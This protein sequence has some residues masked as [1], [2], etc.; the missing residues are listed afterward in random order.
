MIDLNDVRPLGFGGD[1]YDLDAIV[2]GLRTATASWVPRHFPCGRRNGDE[3]RLANILGAAPRKTGSCVITLTGAHAG[4]WIDFETNEGGGPLSALE[5]ATGL[6]GRALIEYA[7]E[8]AGSVAVRSTPVPSSSDRSKDARHEIDIVLARCLPVRGTPVEAYLAGRGLAVPDLS[9][10]LFHPDLTYWETRTG[11]PALV[12]VV[13]NAGGEAVAIH[14]TYLAPN[15]SG[16]ADVLKPR[17]MLGPVSGGAVQ[18][19]PISG[20]GVLGLAEGIETALSVMQACPELPVWA[21]LSAGNLERVILPSDA[22]SIVLLADHDESG[23][24]LEAARKAAERLTAEGRQV[25]LAAPPRAGDD[26]NDLLHRDGL[27]AV[28]TV[29]HTAAAWAPAQSGVTDTVR[30][31]SRAEREQTVDDLPL[32][33]TE[34]ALALEFSARYAEDLRFCAAWG[35]WLMWE[36]RYWKPDETLRAFDLSR[37]TCRAASNRALARIENV[38]AA[39]RMAAALA[40]AKTV[41]AVERLAKADRRHAATVEQW[42]SDEWLLNTPDGIVDLATGRLTPH[43]RDAY[44]TKIAAVGPRGRCPQWRAFLDR[45]SDGD[46]DLQAFL[47]RVAGSALTG[48]IRDHALFFLYGTGRNG[49][50]VFLNTLTRILGDYAVVASIETFT[51][52]NTDRHTTDLAMLRGARLVSAQETEEG[53]RWAESRIKALTGGDPITARF[54]RQDNFTFEPQFKL[55]IA[56]N[57]KPGLRNVDEAIR[58][59]FNLIPFTVTIPESERDPELPAKLQAEWPG[60]LAWAIEGCL[61]W[62]RVGLAPPKAVLDAT[63]A[64][65]EVE[66]ALGRF[67]EERCDVGPIDRLTGEDN[68]ATSTDL[69]ASWQEWCKSTGEY[70]GTQK[71]F[72]QNMQARGFEPWKHPTTRRTGFRGVRLV[73]RATPGTYR[74]PDEG[75]HDR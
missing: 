32:D 26:F 29:V 65:M 8:L 60:I 22:T 30:D 13:R 7:A 74:T 71:R 10:L 18:L 35:R 38:K 72:S 2:A 24:G 64:Y 66:D 15:G 20:D 1:R 5:Y 12:A 17:M 51:A 21:V 19:A 67:L 25:W 43:R 61:E 73:V 75:D 70:A 27:D 47:Q 3:W 55:I 44:M 11:Y 16:K 58:A 6:S 41:A 54:M 69:F 68:V 40:S 56:G 50:G 14:R 63:T 28:R 37:G 57:H 36:G 46:V 48:S 39:A 33:F 53:R 52:T 45:V 49:K 62:Q 42:D 59:R 31:G 23:A 34:E 4:D 9:D